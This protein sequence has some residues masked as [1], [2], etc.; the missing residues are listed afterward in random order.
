MA[1][2][3]S[4]CEGIIVAVVISMIIEA[5]LPEGNQK[6]YVKVVIGIYLIFTILNP[7]LGKQE[8]DFVPELDFD[9]ASVE[10]ASV[11]TQNIQSLY[12]SGIQETLKANL[13]EEFNCQ[14]KEIDIVYDEAYQNIKTITLTIVEEG[15]AEIETVAIGNTTNNEK[16]EKQNVSQIK[17]YIAEHY[18]VQPSQIII[19]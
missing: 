7:L 14:I 12:I 16:K 11:D 5:I 3:K 17:T 10:T 15:I 2:L 8:I 19:Q 9:L 1:F 13:E 18:E 6:K 4:W